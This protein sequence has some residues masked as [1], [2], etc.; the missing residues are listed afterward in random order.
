LTDRTSSINLEPDKWR[1]LVAL[2]SAEKM[3]DRS[4]LRY[5]EIAIA[6]TVSSDAGNNK[7]KTTSSVRALPMTGSSCAARFRSL[8]LAA[9][10]CVVALHPA[11]GSLAADLDAQGVRQALAAADRRTPPDFAGK[12]LSGLDL[13]GL[14]FKAANLAGAVFKRAKLAGANL[15][16]ANLD[17]AILRDAD[18]NGAD[19]GGASLFSTVLAG[20]DLRNANLAGARLVAN[21]ERTDLSGAN[22]E[23]LRGGADMK[24]Q[25][26]GLMRLSMSKAKLVGAK[27]AGADL[28]RALLEFADLSKA[29]LRGANLAQADLSAANLDGAAL[30]GADL[31]GANLL[32]ARLTG[33]TGRE[34]IKGL[35]SAKNLATAKFD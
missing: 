10:I 20:A 35:D 2:G 19:L 33:I 14:D 21:L 5:F 24:N 32:H 25:P 17:L 27:L 23:R 30:A 3:F 22:L 6:Y 28:S 4:R 9:A 11:D 16:G 12:D 7:Q 8:A 31:T 1:L 29:D 15:S 26:M 18:L 34:A 13:A